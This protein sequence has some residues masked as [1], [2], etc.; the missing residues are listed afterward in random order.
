MPARKKSNKITTAPKGKSFKYVPAEPRGPLTHDWQ[1]KH[2]CGGEIVM[3]EGTFPTCNGGTVFVCTECDWI[4]PDG[5]THE[6]TVRT[7]VEWGGPIIRSQPS[8]RQTEDFIQ[9]FRAEKSKQMDRLI[10]E[11]A[12]FP[13]S[14][15]KKGKY[16]KG[17]KKGQDR[18]VNNPKFTD[19]M[20]EHMH[21]FAVDED[22]IS[23]AIVASGIRRFV[24]PKAKGKV[25]A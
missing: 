21:T 10:K 1:H 16:A 13:P 4:S 12:K 22:A 25:K 2:K 20:R 11:R 18:W 8:K 19:E 23:E 14:L 15:L 17:P 9:A 6:P 24:A 3:T 7:V 5:Y